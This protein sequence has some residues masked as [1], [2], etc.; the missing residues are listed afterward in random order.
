MTKLQKAATAP[1]AY[2]QPVAVPY[3][4]LAPGAEG[5]IDGYVDMRAYLRISI[6]SDERRISSRRKAS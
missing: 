3:T 1:P 2:P 6:S 4:R 5:G